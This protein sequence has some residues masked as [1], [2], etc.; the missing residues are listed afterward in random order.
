[1]FAK[2]Y[3]TELGQILVKID[4]GNNGAEVRLFFE[5][6]NLGVCSVAL[7]WEGDDDETQWSKAEASFEAMTE[8]F[9]LALLKKTLESLE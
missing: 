5:P 7:S 1:M 4:E 6:K 9:S 2:L 8:E 3:E